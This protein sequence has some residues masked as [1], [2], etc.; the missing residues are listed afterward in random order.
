MWLAVAVALPLALAV[1]WVPVRQRLPNVDVALALVAA[2]M[3]TGA[4]RRRHA[5][6]VAAVVAAAAFAFFDTRPFDHWAMSRQPDVETTVALVVV[7]IAAGELA[8]RV[9]RQ[10]AAAAGTDLSRVQDTAA[11]L[12]TGE[13]LAV[14]IAAVAEELATLLLLADCWFDSDPEAWAGA[15][16]DRDGALRQPQSPRR[17]RRGPGGA[18]EVAL[19]VW[20]MG[21]VLGRFVLRPTPGVAL[22]HERLL[23]AVTLADQVGAGLAAQAP[24][25]APPPGSPLAPLPPLRVVR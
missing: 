6:V 18:D 9:A 13:E 22:T 15:W 19:P 7:G 12:A 5:V 21:Q 25:P 23:V 16:V 1:A 20:G 3:V 14:I 8:L 4:S 2:V 24:P 11:L 10:R 17:R